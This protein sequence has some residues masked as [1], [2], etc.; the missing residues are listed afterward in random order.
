MDAVLSS[1][2]PAHRTDEGARGGGTSRRKWAQQR[3]PDSSSL[4]RLQQQQIRVLG[5]QVIDMCC[6]KS[7]ILYTVVHG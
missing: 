1:E 7:G 2:Q 5:P 6:Y 4:A 3:Y